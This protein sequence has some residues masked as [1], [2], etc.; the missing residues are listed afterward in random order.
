MAG[1]SDEEAGDDAAAEHALA[2]K[3]VKASEL[4]R[5]AFRGEML[6]EDAATDDAAPTEEVEG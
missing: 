6:G 3:I 5:Q 2:E 4:F 1:R